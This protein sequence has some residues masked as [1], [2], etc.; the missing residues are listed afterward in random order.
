[1][2]VVDATREAEDLEKFKN[3]IKL[4][5]RDKYPNAKN[6][7]INISGDRIDISVRY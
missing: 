6:I 4:M 7:S 1:M 2:K 5:F 3:Q